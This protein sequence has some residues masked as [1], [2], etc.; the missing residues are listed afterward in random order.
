LHDEALRLSID[1]NDLSATLEQH[2]EANAASLLKK[3]PDGRTSQDADGEEGAATSPAGA[4]SQSALSSL[5]QERRKAKDSA[6]GFG[7]ISSILEH[8]EEEPGTT[9][10]YNFENGFITKT[11]ADAIARERMAVLRNTELGKAD[12]IPHEDGWKGQMINI[13]EMRSRLPGPRRTH[14]QP[15]TKVDSLPDNILEYV[16]L[17]V[18]PSHPFS[19][20]YRTE[21]WGI[22]RRKGA[23]MIQ[24]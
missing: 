17:D 1:P 2:R 13:R 7:D 14:K 3:I 20:V 10:Q 19:R 24:V 6:P 22:E 11:M 23:D 21:P 5:V 18:K 15:P 12:K 16:G 4:D 8:P 9:D